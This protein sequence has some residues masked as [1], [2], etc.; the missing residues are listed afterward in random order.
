MSDG[1]QE[2]HISRMI[3]EKAELSNKLRKLDNFIESDKFSTLNKFQKY[4]MEEQRMA[5][6]QYL[7]ILTARIQSD[8]FVENTTLHSATSVG[9]D[10][11]TKNN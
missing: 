7:D 10:G 6:S 8:K 11:S 3:T 5:M 9:D 1:A 4:L 2:T